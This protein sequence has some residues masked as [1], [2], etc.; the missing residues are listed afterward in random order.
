MTILYILAAVLIFGFLIA[1]HELG[2]FLAAKSCGVRVHEFSIGMGPALFKKQKGDTLYA[3]RCLPLGGYCAM[4]GEDEKSDDPASLSRQGFWAKLLVF[5]AGALMNFVAGLLVLLCLYGGAKA[6]TTTSIAGF[7]EGCPLEGTLQAEDCL[8]SIDG[9]RV[10]VYSD[11]SMLMSLNRTGRFDLVVKR[12]G[13]KVELQDI[14]MERGTYTDQN[15]QSYTGYGLLF[16]IQQVNFGDRL[17]Y[18]FASAVDFIRMVRLSLKMILTGQAGFG[19]ISGPV[20]IVSTITDVGQ[21]SPTTSAAVRSIAYFA[22]MI[23][24]NLGVMNLL[25]LPALDGGKIFFLLVNQLSYLLFR[26]RIPEKFENYIHIVG[27]VLLMLLMLAVTFKDVWK[28]F[29]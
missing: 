27:F 10:Y 29:T 11:I 4:E 26:R 6:L 7:A 12:G 23:A 25:P 15:G 16:S 28:L 2:H 1:V 18:C 14:A 22:A 3:L 20:G 8:L 17:R 13:E 19:D 5:A 24:M 9:E 21:N